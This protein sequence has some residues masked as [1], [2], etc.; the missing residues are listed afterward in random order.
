MRTSHR[1]AVNVAMGLLGQAFM[2]RPLQADIV[3]GAKLFKE[4]CAPC[5]SLRRGVDRHGPSLY[6]VMGRQAGMQPG[7]E[8][9]ATLPR[10]GII[11]NGQTLDRWLREP[12]GAVPGAGMPF[13]GLE[14][15][16]QRTNVVEFLEHEATA[17]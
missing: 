8:Y 14:D 17:R 9:S 10:S 7:F 15:T 12:H 2:P 4:R 13:E 1:L 11:W 3:A 5:H 6:R 16:A